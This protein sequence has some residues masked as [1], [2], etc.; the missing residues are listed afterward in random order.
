[1]TER[2]DRTGEVVIPLAAGQITRALDGIEAAGAEAV[3]ICTL[4]SV[5][6]PVHE[7]ALA[8][9]V[10]DRFPD[11]FVT[12]SHAVAPGV[13]EYARMST[14]AANAALGPVMGAYLAAWTR[15]CAR[16]GSGC[17]CR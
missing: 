8:R 15:R 1:M 6:N 17:R 14:T 16:S 9:A 4:W 3:A 7:I 2:V 5:V 12:V 11:L 13:G 10:R